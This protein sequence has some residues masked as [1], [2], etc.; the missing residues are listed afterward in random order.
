MAAQLNF[1]L[2]ASIR[3]ATPMDMEKMIEVV[4]AAFAIE[5][6]LEST[7]T[8]ER[9]M[10][11]MM[12]KGEFLVSEGTGGKIVACI[13]VERRVERGY[14]GMLAVDPAHQH[15]G[16]GRTMVGV[17]ESHCCQRGCAAMDITVLSLRPELVAF[18]SR[19]GYVRTGTEEFHPSRP[20]KAGVTCHGIVMSKHLRLTATPRNWAPHVPTLAGNRIGLALRTQAKWRW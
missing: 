20:L 19:L 13:Y 8:D 7:R 5:T 3:V 16:L 4:N 12:R 9:R 11:E 2:P 1:D 10:A 15:K 6:F 18:Y 14:F 17:A